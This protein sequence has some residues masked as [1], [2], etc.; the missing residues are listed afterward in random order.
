M[1]VLVDFGKRIEPSLGLRDLLPR[2]EFDRAIVGGVDHVLADQDQLPP[3]SE[4]MDGVSVF[5][6]ID[7]GRGA[8][9]EPAKVLRHRRRRIDR[10]EILKE[11]LEGD[12][13]CLLARGDQPRGHLKDALVQGVVEM[14]WLEEIRDA[15]VRR[16]ADEDGAEQRLLGLDVVRCRAQRWQIGRS[17]R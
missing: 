4:I 2:W 16:V 9:G 12:R 17:V 6:G 8:G 3:G 13:G 7:D 15:V 11:G 10:L 1:P 14:R 5:A